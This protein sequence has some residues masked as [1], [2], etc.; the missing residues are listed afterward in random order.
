MQAISGFH[1]PCSAKGSW[2]FQKA[3]LQIHQEND[4]LKSALIE[5]YFDNDWLRR[6][7]LC[8]AKSGLVN[9]MPAGLSEYRLDIG[10][11]WVGDKLCLRF[12][13]HKMQSR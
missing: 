6:A 8:V 7:S 11:I 5:I 12:R 9:W 3:P 4:W 1:V 10:L 13:D 2:G